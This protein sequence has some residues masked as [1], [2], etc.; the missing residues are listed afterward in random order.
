[1]IEGEKT[2]SVDITLKKNFENKNIDK[3][4]IEYLLQDI[5]K[6]IIK[7]HPDKNCTYHYKQMLYGWREYNNI[8][9]GKRCKSLVIEINFIY[10]QKSFISSLELI[11]KKHQI[12]T[13]RIICTN[14]AKSLLSSDLEDLPK[15]GLAALSDRNLNEISTYSKKSSKLGFF[16]K[17]FHVF[18]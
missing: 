16:E 6:Q 14:Y 3:T 17:L 2:N 9:L 7:N 5:R 13:D 15:A 18:S 1:M 12:D 8:P 11:L 10:F 4:L